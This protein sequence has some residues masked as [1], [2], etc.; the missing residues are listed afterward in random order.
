MRLAKLSEANRV[1]ALYPDGLPASTPSPHSRD[2]RSGRDDEDRRHLAHDPRRQPASLGHKIR[3]VTSRFRWLEGEAL[4]MPNPPR[5]RKDLKLGQTETG[6]TE[7]SALVQG[8][9]CDACVATRQGFASIAGS[10]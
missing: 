3:A 1:L 9:L 5:K 6:I 8:C 10:I 2:R 7:A 4:C